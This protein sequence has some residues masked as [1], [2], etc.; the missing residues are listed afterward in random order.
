MPQDACVE[1]F[2]GSFSFYFVNATVASSRSQHKPHF[3]KKAIILNS[4]FTVKFHAE[5][6]PFRALALS[7][8][9]ALS[10]VSWVCCVGGW[11]WRFLYVSLRSVGG[12]SEQLCYCCGQCEERRSREL[13]RNCEI[14]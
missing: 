6:F 7:A 2:V 9:H 14:F 5:S 1:S 10:L 13:L 4:C 11:L 8:G 12:A 3:L